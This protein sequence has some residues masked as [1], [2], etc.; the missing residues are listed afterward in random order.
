MENKEI[1][2]LLVTTNYFL[3]WIKAESYILI[4]DYNV[5]R[6]LWKNIICLSIFPKVLI[7][8]NGSQFISE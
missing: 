4:R 3:K 1:K 8:D 5:E 2:Y 6:F 7:A